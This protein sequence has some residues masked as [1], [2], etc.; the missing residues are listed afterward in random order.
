MQTQPEAAL[1]DHRA[2]YAAFQAGG[3]E[4]VNNAIEISSE[5]WETNLTYP[6]GS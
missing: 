6:D 1:K 3:Q 4:G 5:S 2:I